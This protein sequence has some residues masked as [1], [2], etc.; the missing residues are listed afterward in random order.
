MK[1]QSDLACDRKRQAEMAC[2]RNC[3]VTIWMTGVSEKMAALGKTLASA[4]A[5]ALDLPKVEISPAF[6]EALSRISKSYDTEVKLSPCPAAM[7]GMYP[8]NS[9]EV[10]TPVHVAA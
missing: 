2:P 8:V 6:T 3:G 5:P 10:C 4:Y 9:V 7:P 1:A